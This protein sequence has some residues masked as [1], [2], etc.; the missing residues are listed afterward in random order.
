[1][2]CN[3]DFLKTSSLHS[4]T[5]A[6]GNKLWADMTPTE[7]G[8]SPSFFGRGFVT[9]P[10]SGLRQDSMSTAADDLSESWER[11][12]MAEDLESLGGFERAVSLD[13]IWSGQTSAQSVN[14]SGDAWRSNS[15]KA[16]S[17]FS[18][19]AAGQEEH[20][21]GRSPAAIPAGAEA[22]KW[23]SLGSM[24]H[25]LGNCKPCAWFY[26]RQGCQNGLDCRH[27]HACPK[28]EI[29][30]RKKDRLTKSKTEQ[31]VMSD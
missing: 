22:G 24:E 25:D 16:I 14:G 10:Q 18:I 31:Q 13:S 8:L 26:K 4:T 2:A 23:L 15:K 19:G 27:C 20:P 1:M 29:R 3:L 28:G 7:E 9:K 5:S 11:S 6:R 17:S 30:R 21:S 12:T